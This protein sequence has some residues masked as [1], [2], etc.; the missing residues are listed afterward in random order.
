[1]KVMWETTMLSL[2]YP[3]LFL[4]LAMM[5]I[6]FLCWAWFF[7]ARVGARRGLFANAYAAREVI[8][9]AR[10]PTC[11]CAHL[12]VR[13]CNA[14]FPRCFSFSES[15]SEGFFSGGPWDDMT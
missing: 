5:G 2:C 12:R 15:R 6:L 13:V 9:F 10:L 1:M 11:R 3:L 4:V 8:A 7:Y 14:H